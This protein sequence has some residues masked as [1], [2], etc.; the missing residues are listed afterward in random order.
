[1]TKLISFIIPAYNAAPFLGQC[2]D[3]ILALRMKD[4]QREIIVIDDGSS[5]NTPVLLQQ[6]ADRHKEITIATQANSGQGAARNK[7]IRMAKGSYLCFVDSDDSLS[8]QAVLPFE[9]MNEEADMISLEITRVK[10]DGSR[11]SYRSKTSGNFMGAACAYIVRRQFLEDHRIL[12]PEGIYH[13]DEE[14]CVKARTMAQRYARHT[15]EFYLYYERE[16]STCT[17]TSKEKQAKRLRDRYTVLEDLV[18]FLHDHPELQ[19][20][21]QTKMDFLTLDILIHLQRTKLDSALEHEI[22]E[23]LKRLGLLPL[24]WRTNLH[25]NIIRL[26]LTLHLY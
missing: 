14:F 2:L 4:W 10:R 5:D 9:A 13:E 18:A 17:C 24:P 12:F 11:T 21:V 16:D 7:A 1:M 26:K 8:P 25:Y 23:N 20:R 3:S 6:Y 22:K 15:G 19:E